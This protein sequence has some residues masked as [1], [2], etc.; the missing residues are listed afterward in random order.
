MQSNEFTQLP[1]QQQLDTLYFTGDV[2]ANRYEGDE[3][4]LLY[5]LHNF[6]VE[7]RYNAYNSTIKAVTTFRDTDRLEPYLP[8]LA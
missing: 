3:I 5:N 8:Y 1:I 4:F 2:L 7:L 6:Y